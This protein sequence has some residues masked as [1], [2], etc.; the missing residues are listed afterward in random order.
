MT[1]NPIPK[2]SVLV[3]LLE[4]GQVVRTR[5]VHGRNVRTYLRHLALDGPEVRCRLNGA[6]CKKRDFPPAGSL[7]QVWSPPR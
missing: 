3:H 2:D 6:L 4:S 5:W 1:D 7:L